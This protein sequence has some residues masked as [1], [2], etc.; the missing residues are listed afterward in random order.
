[1]PRERIPLIRKGGFADAEKLF[2]LS[3][4]GSKSEK[5][6]F[7]DFRVSELF[8][9]NGLIETI[10]LKRDKKSGTDPISVKKLLKKAKNE[11]PFK[12]SD[13]FWLIIDRDDWETSHKQNF[14]EL[15]EDCKAEN[16]FF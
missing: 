6:Y 12:K 4:E 15:V 9:D 14:C 16:N 7:E 13:E 8:N 10:P 11:F 1:M 2:V 3:F 5:K